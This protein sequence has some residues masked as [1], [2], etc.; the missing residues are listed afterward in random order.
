MADGDEITDYV[1]GPRNMFRQHRV[2][3]GSTL[4]R[5]LWTALASVLPLGILM[6][7]DI[8][9]ALSGPDSANNPDYAYLSF[10]LPREAAGAQKVTYQFRYELCNRKG[11]GLA[12][13]WDE[14]GFGMS[15]REPLSAY[16]CATFE[17][18]GDDITKS[19]STLIRL[20]GRDHPADAYLP[21]PY[22]D[23]T[24]NRTRFETFI[25]HAPTGLNSPVQVTLISRSIENNTG[26][27][28]DIEWA[29]KDSEF[30]LSFPEMKD[31]L[32]TLQANAKLTGRNVRFQFVTFSSFAEL[33]MLERY[34]GV[35]Q[36]K[37]V[38]TRIAPDPKE[39]FG[40]THIEFRKI[41]T[42]RLAVVVITDRDGRI[43]SAFKAPIGP[44]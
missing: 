11:V 5:I 16:M 9:L 28:L 34:L 1:G 13:S 29:A 19:T 27:E 23:L 20:S 10:V 37:L 12:F 2:I 32:E 8:P 38:V 22:G 7:Q 4:S 6:A 44:P 25:K 15:L 24:N 42:G 30:I 31:D 33:P 35:P 43:L 3:R 18:G 36:S 39:E 17:L 40:R 26:K 41:E 14:P 21:K